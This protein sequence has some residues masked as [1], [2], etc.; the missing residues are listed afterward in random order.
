MQPDRRL[1]PSSGYLHQFDAL[2]HYPHGNFIALGDAG[3]Y[4]PFEQ[5]EHFQ[6]LMLDWLTQNATAFP[7]EGTSG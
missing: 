7:E 2:T 4:V 5:P 6:A 3:H 1:P